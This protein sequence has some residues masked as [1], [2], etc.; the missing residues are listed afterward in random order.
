MIDINYWPE[1]QSIKLNLAV[2]NLFIQTYQNLSYTINNKTG[3]ILAIDL[4]DP[5]I[6]QYLL[7]EILIELEILILDITEA[8]IS[9]NYFHK[10]KK[11]IIDDLLER[12]K[13][14]FFIKFT[15][16]SKKY[17]IANQ[18]EYIKISKDTKLIISIL[19]TYLIYGSSYLNTQF[20]LFFNLKTPN[21]HVKLL[22]EHIIIDIGNTITL[23]IIQYQPSIYKLHD[24]LIY[25]R[26]VHIKYSSLR[27]LTNFQ[28]SL[29][30]N[31]YLYTQIKYPT[32]IYNCVCQIYLLEKGTIFN[33]KIYIYRNNQYNRI[34]NLQVIVIILLEIQDFILPKINYLITL[35]GKF[36]IF[37]IYDIIHKSTIYFTNILIKN[38]IHTK[39][40]TL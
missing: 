13:Y 29:S 40:R 28:N 34:S 24:F 25:N 8:N 30:S 9:I 35:L 10:L 32:Q 7:A 38:I 21:Y 39:N 6:Q 36:V 27:T 2:A 14:K 1:K 33:K 19:L 11:Q 16:I 15:K 22:F 17:L 20:F 18:Y 26:L 5:H 23:Q 12:I 4:F 3:S 31:N 37:I